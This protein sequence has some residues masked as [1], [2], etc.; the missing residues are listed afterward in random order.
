MNY[1]D[2][3]TASFDRGYKERFHQLILQ[4]VVGA[5]GGFEKSAGPVGAASKAVPAMSQAISKVAPAVMSR[6][7][8]WGARLPGALV[9]GG[10]LAGSKVPSVLPELGAAIESK[11]PGMAA[12][13]GRQIPKVVSRGTQLEFPLHK[14]PVQPLRGTLPSVAGRGAQMDFPNMA[15]RMRVPWSAK[16]PA[17]VAPEGAAIPT[18][19]AGVPPKTMP[20]S[21]SAGKA[22]PG[23]G[24]VTGA[25][26]EGAGAGKGTGSGGQTKGK[27]SG[28]SKTIDP[29]TAVK[30][31]AGSASAT[32]G[33]PT[34]G[35]LN[36]IYAKMPKHWQEWAEGH[37]PQ[38]YG[39]G[40][41]LAGAAGVGGLHAY[42][43]SRRR[44]AL[45]NLS[46]MQRLG[47]AL[48]LAAN[49]EGFINTLHL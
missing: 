30:A 33:D 49:P 37:K 22:S 26:S 28:E 16:G 29:E 23:T 41:A 43:D 47:L 34:A 38:L 48:Q 39:A 9:E 18:A 32:E 6:A 15:G 44:K 24:T 40:G 5:T 8:H 1:D 36:R 17:S 21:A 46:F 31:P 13:L 12:N 42:G 3:K 35:L 7:P 19:A 2:A 14:L 20:T 27:P 25:T 11:V 10:L 45:E 4:T